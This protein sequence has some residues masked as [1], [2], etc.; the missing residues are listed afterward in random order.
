MI[1]LDYAANTPVDKEVLDYY[2]DIS[3]K[4]YGNPN[5]KHILGR[6]AKRVVDESTK[7]IAKLLN[8]R[9]DEIIYTSGSTESNNLALKGVA[10]KYK[11]KGKH[12]IISALEHSSVVASANYLLDQGFDIDILPVKKDGLV[13]IDEL[14][15]LLRDD[16][17]LVSVTAVDSEIG[18][19][20]P[21][22]EIGKLLKKYPNTYFHTDATGAIGKVDIDFKDVDLVTFTPHKF[23]GI[24]GMGV[25]IKKENVDLVPIINGGRSTT[26]YRSGTPI[27]PLIAATAKA[28]DIAL[29][30]RE[31]RF[32]YVSKL[33]K[34][35]IDHLKKYDIVHINNTENSIP[36][37]INFS[38]KGVNSNDFAKK[39]DEE[40]VCI[41]T[42]TSC[43]LE[44]APSR[45]VYALTKDKNLSKES[46]RVSLSHLT[47]SKE[48]N[49][50]FKIFDKCLNEVINKNC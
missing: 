19:K 25:L 50:F 41:S 36:F 8:V 32:N 10:E 17:I 49:E 24:N 34:K 18:L 46:L 14:K 1:Y 11:E 27:V 26:I 9:E 15:R 7:K 23:Y 30:K 6:E 43:S 16:T 42:K 37:T 40:G 2:Y 13:D 22:E 5:S 39:M 4:Y 28:L 29:S 31:E 44:K 21:I 20:Q 38:I 12:I 47:A 48:I 3:L 35:I 33:N 45:A